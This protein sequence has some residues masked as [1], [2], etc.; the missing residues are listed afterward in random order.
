MYVVKNIPKNLDPN[1]FYVSGAFMSKDMPS[2]AGDMFDYNTL[3]TARIKYNERILGKTALGTADHTMD[4]TITN[5]DGTQ[6]YIETMEK[7]GS[8]EKVILNVVDLHWEGN[9]L[10]GTAQL[11]DCDLSDNLIR[12]MISG[13]R[14]GISVHGQ[15]TRCS[16]KYVRNFV[17]FSFDLVS[18]PADPNAIVFLHKG[19]E[20]TILNSS[21]FENNLIDNRILTNIKQKT[22]NKTLNNN[23]KDNS[24]LKKYRIKQSD[25]TEVEFDGEI[26]EANSIVAPMVGGPSTG[27]TAEDALN[28]IEGILAQVQGGATE[29]PADTTMELIAMNNKKLLSVAQKL[30]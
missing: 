8:V 11:L 23:G 5:A 10:C 30:I 14:M 4:L 3:E 26:I 19:G 7:I 16:D 20:C 29:I 22:L 6:A 13:C 17:I 28:Q 12:K 1:K 21:K 15:G 2:S 25:G 24:M 9:F 18:D 27:L